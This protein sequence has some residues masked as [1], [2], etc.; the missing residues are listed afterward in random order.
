ML[1]PWGPPPPPP[2]G[3]RR[4]ARGSVYPAWMGE[5]PC[6]CLGCGPPS[7][8]RHPAADSH[9]TLGL[10]AP[11]DPSSG[12]TTQPCWEVKPRTGPRYQAWCTCLGRCDHSRRL[13]LHILRLDRSLHPKPSGNPHPLPTP[14][15]PT[16]KRGGLHWKRTK[17][18]IP[19]G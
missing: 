5:G 14:P 16:N 17:L 13:D 19:F 11:W 6:P 2:R 3:G 8:W 4:T 12:N 7:G 15:C 9:S 10:R 18:H 1:A